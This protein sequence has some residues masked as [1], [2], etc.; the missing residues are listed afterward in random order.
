MARVYPLGDGF[1][2]ERLFVRID[3]SKRM[4]RLDGARQALVED[5]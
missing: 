5:I 3:G 1:P 2:E 4:R